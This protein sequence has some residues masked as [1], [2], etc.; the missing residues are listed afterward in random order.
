MA[1][2]S[3]P[4]FRFRAALAIFSCISLT[5]TYL[6][7]KSQNISLG[8][9]LLN[10]ASVKQ[11]NL[12]NANQ[13]E[14]SKDRTAQ[15]LLTSLPKK[16]NQRFAHHSTAAKPYPVVDELL[17]YKF[18]LNGNKIFQTAKLPGSKVSF[19]QSDLLEVQFF[20]N[21]KFLSGT[22][23]SRSLKIE[24]EAAKVDPSSSI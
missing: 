13:Q 3:N 7:N 18:S 17:R 19:N 4:K 21:L 9:K 10:I 2:L 5:G 20:F 15:K 1:I 23:R 8:G 6:Y 16:N 14:A 22:R 12:L 24:P 11:I